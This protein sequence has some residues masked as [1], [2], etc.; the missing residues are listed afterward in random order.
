MTSKERHEV[1][2]QRRKARRKRNRQQRSDE[3]GGLGNVFAYHKL[4][5]AGLKCCNG[6]RW[7]FSVQRHEVHL[8]SGSAVKHT[9]IMEH[10]YNFSACT[11]FMLRERGKIRPI[12]APRVADRQVEKVYSQE[13]LYPLYQPVMIFNNGASIKGKGLAFTRKELK[14]EITE[15]YRL[16]GH[17]GWMIFTDGKGF[18]PNAPHWKVYQMHERYI[19]DNDLRDFGDEIVRTMPNEKGMAIGIEPSQLE[20]VA[21]PSDMDNHIKAQR[22]ARGYGHYMDDWQR[23]VTPHEDV[24]EEL[25]DL[26]EQADKNGI[27]LNPS[28]TVVKSFGKDFTYCKARY[29]I[30]E[31]G[32][33]VVRANRK[34]MQRDRRKVRAFRKKIDR[35][36][37]TFDDLWASMNGMIAYLKQFDE[38]KNVLRLYRMFYALFG[39]S[40]ENIK[41]FREGALHY[42]IH[43]NQ[44]ISA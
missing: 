39:F 1:R 6:E 18:F 3:L 12:D 9:E 42:G 41:A 30:T 37:M 24:R 27:L 26:R 32:H 2:Y 17:S 13:V 40:C 44:A 14:R 7:K 16:Y 8:F 15:H 29:H 34:A 19:L 33:V 38:H 25:R 22:G 4:H 11:H 36:E 21:L 43:H 20:M 5:R 28:K 23:F 31:T 35:G 10:R